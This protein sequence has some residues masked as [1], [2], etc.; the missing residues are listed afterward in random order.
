MSVS[1]PARP[2]GQGK[3]V[4]GRQRAAHLVAGALLVLYVYLPVA[5]DA[6]L[7]TVVR[8]I[9]FPLLVIT[10]VL[11]WQWPKLR[12]FVRARSDRPRRHPGTTSH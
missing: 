8:W 2:V 1:N 7:Q 6:T 10:G 11:M 4:R 5:P 3:R 9:V 12:R